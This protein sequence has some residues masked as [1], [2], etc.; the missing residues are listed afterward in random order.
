[1]AELEVGMELRALEILAGPYGAITPNA[2]AIRIV[3]PQD[4]DDWPP[5]VTVPVDQSDRAADVSRYVSQLSPGRL[6]ARPPGRA[7]RPAARRPDAECQDLGVGAAHDQQSGCRHTL[8]RWADQVR[9]AAA[10]DH[11]GDSVR[12]LGRGHQS[13]DRTRS[14]SEELGAAR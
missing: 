12:P 13:G 3:R 1:V 11:R 2:S 14:G 10:R 4:V 7:V 8:Q 6:P 5:E 9:S